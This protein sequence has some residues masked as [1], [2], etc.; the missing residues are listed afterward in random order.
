MTFF[1]FLKNKKIF[2]DFLKE[3]FQIETFLL[4]KNHKKFKNKKL[5]KIFNSK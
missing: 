1:K 2:T 3:N 5:K 4:E